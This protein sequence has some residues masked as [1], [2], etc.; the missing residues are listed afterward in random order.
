MKLIFSIL[1]MLS[2]AIISHTLTAA[3]ADTLKISSPVKLETA[4]GVIHG[5]LLVPANKNNIPLVILIAGSGPTDRDGNTGPLKN[6]SLKMLA[7]EL[8]N[9]GIATLRYDKRGIAASKDAGKAEKNL[10][11]EDYIT[12][13]A[14][15]VTQF[16][17]DKRFSKIIIAGHSEG[18]LIGM[19][20]ANNAKAD[21]YISLAGIGQPASKTL[22]TQ[23]QSQSFGISQVVDPIIDSLAMGMTVKKV[24]PALTA[25]F[26][27]SVQPYLISWFKYDP[28]A[29]I[30][31]LTIPTLII[32]GINDIQV[33]TD[34][35]KT[36][37]AAQPK[38]TLVLIDGMNH[39]FKPAPADRGQNFATYK[40]PALPLTPELVPKV[41]SFIQNLK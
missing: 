21:A 23:F 15:W 31:K 35:A 39:I 37:A 24:P 26:R 14:A 10:R 34:D 38:A 3:T 29:E 36:L 28:A 16:R 27:P 18:S 40:D 20:A 6:N 4:T 2:T 13:A 1:C 17:A 12:D 32:Q 9:N 8:A 7:R 25:V 30:K 33:S 19:I 41:T 22:K 11:F 5:T